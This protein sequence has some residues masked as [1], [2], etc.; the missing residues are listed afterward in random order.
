MKGD[1]HEE[2]ELGSEPTAPQQPTEEEE[3]LI[4]P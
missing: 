1:K 4:D 3:A 2:Q